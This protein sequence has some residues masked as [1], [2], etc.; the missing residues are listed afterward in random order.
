MKA[1]WALYE[2]NDNCKQHTGGQDRTEMLK[3]LSNT[4][5]PAKTVLSLTSLHYRVKFQN[6]KNHGKRSHWTSAALTL[7]FCNSGYWLLF[8]IP[9]SLVIW[10]YIIFTNHQV[11]DRIVCM[12]WQPWLCDYRQRP[13]VCVRWILYIPVLPGHAAINQRCLQLTAKWTRRGLKQVS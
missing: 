3:S 8:R 2:Q 7:A 10:R 6:H 1:I 11:V 9:W 12:V 4:V 5:P 13:T